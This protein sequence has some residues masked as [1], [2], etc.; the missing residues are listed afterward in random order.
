MVFVEFLDRL[1]N[2]L[3]FKVT[4]KGFDTRHCSSE[5]QRIV[6]LTFRETM[7]EPLALVGLIEAIQYINKFGLEGD[8]VECGVWR[9][10]S[11]M[12]AA[13]QSILDGNLRKIWLYDTYEG[14]TPPQENLDTRLMTNKPVHVD[15]Y[16]KWN[17]PLELVKQN[18]EKT[19]YQTNLIEY[20][21]G[22]VLDTL[23]VRVP[24]KIALLRLDTDWYDSTKIE[25]E[26]LFPLLTS[27]GILIIDDY[28]YFSGSKKACDEYF[29]DNKIQLMLSRIGSVAAMGVK[30]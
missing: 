5:T 12:A 8:I 19:G 23:K 29:Q 26:Y 15:E 25:L 6:D 18:L 22:S 20:V 16:E 21:R 3:G 9:G 7:T 2:P 28:H 1:A 11:M 10:G 17:A 24:S 30:Q 14:M 4:K 27:G 13:H